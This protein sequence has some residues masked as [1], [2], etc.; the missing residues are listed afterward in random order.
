MA[1]RSRMLIFFQKLQA[2]LQK[3]DN[4]EYDGDNDGDD[5]VDDD[6]VD[7]D[8]VDDGFWKQ[9]TNLLPKAMIFAS[10]SHD[11]LHL[12]SMTLPHGVRTILNLK[13][14]YRSKM[15]RM[16]KKMKKIMKMIMM[17]MMKVLMKMMIKIMM[18]SVMKIMMKMMMMKMMVMKIVMKM[19]MMAFGNRIQFCFQKP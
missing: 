2:L 16:R 7:D 9:N 18:K 12:K 5:D 11:F 1:F 3:V 17:L 19:L 10:N 15:M 4:D 8:D 6:D 14:A 13:L